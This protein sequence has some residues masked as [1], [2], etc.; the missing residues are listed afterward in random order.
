M[1]AFYNICVPIS[2]YSTADARELL[3]AGGGGFDVVARALK[4]A[5]THLSESPETATRA[6]HS[7]T[8]TYLHYPG[9]KS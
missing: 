3:N 1:E 5:C 7:D 9:R 4:A 8:T 6:S 2:S